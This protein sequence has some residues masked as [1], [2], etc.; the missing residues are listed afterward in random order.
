MA[1][2]NGILALLFVASLAIAVYGLKGKKRYNLPPGPKGLPIIGSAFDN[3][4]KGYQWL[5]YEKWG[6]QYGARLAFPSSCPHMLRKDY[7]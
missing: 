1:F 5:A 6:K 3:A 4:T 7:R 2:D